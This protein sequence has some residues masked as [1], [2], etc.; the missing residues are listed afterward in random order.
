MGKN[1]IILSILVTMA[2]SINDATFQQLIKPDSNDDLNLDHEIAKI[3]RHE[4]YGE[5]QRNRKANKDMF[6]LF[7]HP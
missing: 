1:I 5:L 7:Y 2:F 3:G 6:V 4:I